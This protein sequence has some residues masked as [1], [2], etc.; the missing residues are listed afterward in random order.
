MQ[1]IIQQVI[2]VSGI[3]KCDCADPTSPSSLP[4]LSLPL[5]LPFPPPLSGNKK[6]NR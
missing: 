3:Q 5:H 2:C 1:T 6:K 4:F